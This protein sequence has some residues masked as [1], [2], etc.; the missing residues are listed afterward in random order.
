MRSG[1]CDVVSLYLLCCSVNGSVCFV[2]CM[3]GE[4]IRNMFRC[5]Y[6]FVVGYDGVVKCGWRC[7]IGYTMCGLPKNVCVVPV[8][9]VS[10]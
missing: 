8:V 4:T 6:Y 7:S 1:E 9:P 2:C 10:A 5:V 3:F